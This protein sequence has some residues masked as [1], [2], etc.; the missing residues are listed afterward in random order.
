MGTPCALD[1]VVCG[2]Q[3][4][5]RKGRLIAPYR[6]LGGI[7]MEGV[8]RLGMTKSYVDTKADDRIE[9]GLITG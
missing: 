9:K 2:A 1:W 3:V 8:A 4:P 6:G 7:K 5:A